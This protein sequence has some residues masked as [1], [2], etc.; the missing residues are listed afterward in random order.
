MPKWTLDVDFIFNTYTQCT[1]L[2]TTLASQPSWKQLNLKR[3]VSAGKTT[4]Y[5]ADT[6]WEWANLSDAL[7]KITAMSAMAGFSGATVKYA[8]GEPFEE[9]VTAP[10]T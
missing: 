5:N 9:P 10:A 3:V 6:H 7:A 4:G 2:I 1:A 8:T